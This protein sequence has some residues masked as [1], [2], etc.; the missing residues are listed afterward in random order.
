M[1]FEFPST[2]QNG[3]I[4]NAWKTLLDRW[5]GD[6]LPVSGTTVTA[7]TDLI[8]RPANTTAYTGGSQLIINETTAKILTFANAARIAAGSGYVIGAK[9]SV[10][11][12]NSTNLGCRLWLYT[13]PPTAIAD[14]AAFTLLESS[15][16]IRIG[17]V[18]FTSFVSGGSGSDCI[19]SYSNAVIQ[20]L[21]F[22]AA[23]GL[24]NLYGQLVF[25]N[26]GNYSPGSNQRFR[27][28]LLGVEQ[29]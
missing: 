18:D 13:S 8:T 6:R 15:F 19:E 3:Q 20:N 10:S 25:T 29:N 16:G 7:I 21:P 17:Y 28:A 9:L 2:N 23:S 22:S 4:L 12:T 26:S 1:P 27:V 14:Q 5:S 11:G 24:Q